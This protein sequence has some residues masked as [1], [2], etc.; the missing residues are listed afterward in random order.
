MAGSER[1]TIRCSVSGPIARSQIA[2]LSAEF[3]VRLA[4]LAGPVVACDV[5]HAQPDAA[6]VELLA[7]LQCCARR[8]GCRLR[9]QNASE[10]LL[11]LIAF[12]GLAEALRD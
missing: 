1:Q 10:E 4:S 3:S 11:E 8:A 12:M 2:G 5:R 7:R 9:L 6:T